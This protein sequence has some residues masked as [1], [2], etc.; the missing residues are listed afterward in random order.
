MRGAVWLKA[1]RH[2]DGRG[3]FPCLWQ[4]ADSWQAAERPGRDTEPRGLPLRLPESGKEIGHRE[5][6]T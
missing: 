3:S 6:A 4:V 1:G 2:S 5:Q